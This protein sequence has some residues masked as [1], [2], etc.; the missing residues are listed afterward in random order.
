MVWSV[1]DKNT[2]APVYCLRPVRQHTVTLLGSFAT[3]SDFSHIQQVDSFRAKRYNKEKEKGRE[4]QL[5]KHPN[6]VHIYSTREYHHTY[7]VS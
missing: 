3:Q 7:G 6:E 2:A 1:V 4:L 5:P